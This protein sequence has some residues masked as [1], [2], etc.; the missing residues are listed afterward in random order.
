MSRK[1][2][3]NDNFIPISPIHLV[4]H[5]KL[6]GIVQTYKHYMI[7]GKVKRSLI[8]REAESWLGYTKNHEDSESL[9]PEA[10]NIK[11]RKYKYPKSTLTYRPLFHFH[12]DPAAAMKGFIS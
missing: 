7:Q 6:Y 11:Q 4:S 8:G 1:K 10:Y 12:S 3:E 2:K 9:S 5:K